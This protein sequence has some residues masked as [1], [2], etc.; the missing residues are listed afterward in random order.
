[1]QRAERYRAPMRRATKIATQRFKLKLAPPPIL[2]VVIPV[3]NVESYLSACLKSVA[4]QTLT[5]LEMIVVDDGS[6]DSSSTIIAQWAA[7][8]ARI[9][10]VTVPNSGLGAARNAGA[11]LARGRYLAFVDGDDFLPRDTYAKSISLL[12]ASGSDFACGQIARYTDGELKPLWWAQRLH[13][14]PRVAITI[15]DFP[16]AL[17]DFYTP[18]KVFRRTFW[19]HTSA[20][21]RTGVLFEDQ[22]LISR[23]FLSAHRF[24]WMVDVTYVWRTRA[25]RSS[26]SQNL[27][28]AAAVLQRALAVDL[29][30]PVV[31]AHRDDAVLRAWQWTMLEFHLPQYLS[32]AT[33]ETWETVLSMLRQV[34]GDD[35][36]HE[37]PNVAPT[38]RALLWAAL[39]S[40]G[41]VPTAVLAASRSPLRR[42]PVVWVDGLPRSHAP[43][44]DDSSIPR[45]LFTVDEWFIRAQA[46]VID[47]G[48]SDRG[49]FRIAGR[50]QIDFLDPAKH[51]THVDLLLE[52]EWGSIVSTIPTAQGAQGHFAADVAVE[53]LLSNEATT[54]WTVR[55]VVSV[56]VADRT[57]RSECLLTGVD[58]AL[59][60]G[61]QVSTVAS[62]AD[63]ATLTTL[64]W[65]QDRG[66]QLV[67]ENRRPRLVGVERRGHRALFDLA[68]PEVTGAPM[69][70]LVPKPDAGTPEKRSS[71][72]IAVQRSARNDRWEASVDERTLRNSQ[73]WSLHVRC[74]AE[75]LNP[76]V[77]VTEEVR[78]TLLGHGVGTGHRP[79][80]ECVLTWRRDRTVTQIIVTRHEI[81]VEGTHHAD[82]PVVE[83]RGDHSS[84]DAL[85]MRTE[86]KGALGFAARLDIVTLPTDSGVWR[87]H[88]DGEPAEVASWVPERLRLARPSG[89]VILRSARGRGVQLRLRAP[90]GPA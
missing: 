1:M 27:H 80:G 5:D 24:D 42:Y 18:N 10:V 63:P 26:I 11:K 89:A 70:I 6:T 72:T 81:Y 37:I 47:F 34:L 43:G 44:Y 36:L 54:T 48:S 33:S 45:E 9:R 30:R 61:R 49:R 59:A 71:V 88:V 57:L 35:D 32:H 67:Q 13:D 17:R 46:R 65:T 84:G 87:L 21:F 86:R 15:S 12:E 56:R 77:A 68:M 14:R 78:S 90:T 16:A 53:G 2:S 29:T 23:L 69:V 60:R 76:S 58:G 75:S 74:P 3:Y 38:R 39:H 62:E 31:V 4:E 79:L 25:D 55:A 51:P 52:D 7:R 19:L 40:S 22:P 28:D 66:L 73:E 64:L 83:W 41:D 20:C 85:L 8:D 50:A 82:S